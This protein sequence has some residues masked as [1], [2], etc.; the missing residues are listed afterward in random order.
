MWPL[1]DVV[2]LGILQSAVVLQPVG[3]G[4]GG[5]AEEEADARESHSELSIFIVGHHPCCCL[6]LF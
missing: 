1:T 2:E 5:Q 3:R 6:L 4:Q